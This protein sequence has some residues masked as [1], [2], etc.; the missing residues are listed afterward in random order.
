MIAAIYWFILTMVAA[1][2]NWQLN[3]CTHN[4]TKV[5]LLTIDS[6][7]YNKG[8]VTSYFA[9]TFFM[10]KAESTSFKAFFHQKRP[11]FCCYYHP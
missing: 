3:N 5:I 2:L 4:K 7:T 8:G 1:I 10:I 6:H 11:G 9:L